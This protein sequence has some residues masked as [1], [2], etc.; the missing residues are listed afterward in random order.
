M[1]LRSEG[2]GADFIMFYYAIFD[3]ETGAGQAWEMSMIDQGES[4]PGFMRIPGW[5]AYDSWRVVDGEIV[6]NPEIT[7]SVDSDKSIIAGTPFHL[8]ATC[9]IGKLPAELELVVV[10]PPSLG[11]VGTWLTADTI[12]IDDPGAYTAKVVG[13]WP[14][15][16]AKINLEVLES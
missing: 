7:I 1:L 14:Y 13:P 16:G 2:R 10:K 3:E 9:D 11:V 5:I 8:N 15:Y 12:T 4:G 6:K